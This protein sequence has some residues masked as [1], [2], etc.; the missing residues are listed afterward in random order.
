MNKQ[1]FLE[2]KNLTENQFNGLE[3]I[4]GGLFL[5]MFKSIPK[6]FNPTVNGNLFIDNV[7][8]SQ[9][10]IDIIGEWSHKIFSKEYVISGT[11][12]ETYYQGGN[13]YQNS[14]TFEIKSN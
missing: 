12:T 9:F 13:Q 14:G 8:F 2:K 4:E 7:T 5:S 11:F 10:G 6:G 1:E 3:K